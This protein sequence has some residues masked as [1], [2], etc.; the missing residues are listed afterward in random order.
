MWF[1]F[2]CQPT[3][4]RLENSSFAWL[5]GLWTFVE[6]KERR[7]ELATY[8]AAQALNSLY[9]LGKKKQLYTHTPKYISYLLLII[10]VGILT[11]NI[12]QQP[13]II[14]NLIC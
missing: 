13:Q 7:P 11:C 1:T 4:S 12:D 5:S 2:T 3:M 14:K 6:R 9:I 8:C 10:S